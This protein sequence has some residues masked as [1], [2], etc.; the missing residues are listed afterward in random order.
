MRRA[1]LLL[2]CA[3]ALAAAQDSSI[4]DAEKARLLVKQVAGSLPNIAKFGYGGCCT[5][6]PPNLKGLVS[7]VSPNATAPKGKAP[8]GLLKLGLS[9][10]SGRDGYV[11]VPPSYSPDVPT[12]VI[13]TLHGANKT[14]FNGRATLIDPATAA[15]E[16]GGEGRDGRGA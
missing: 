9:V 5:P 14:A 2:A 10:G 3:A 13:V 7:G 12:P 4:D 16:H 6:T 1:L 15:G 8:V 11:F